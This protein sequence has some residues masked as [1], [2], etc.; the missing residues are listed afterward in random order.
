[1]NS[2]RSGAGRKSTSLSSSSEIRKRPPSK[3]PA[4]IREFLMEGD[5]RSAPEI[6]AH[7]YDRILYQE[8]YRR[9]LDRHLDNSDKHLVVVRGKRR[10]LMAR[11]VQMVAA[12]FLQR[13]RKVTDWSQCEVRLTPA[14]RKSKRKRLPGN[15]SRDLLRQLTPGGEW[16]L[17]AK[18]AHQLTD[19]P[20]MTPEKLEAYYEIQGGPRRTL[21]QRCI[22]AWIRDQARAARGFE[23][24]K[25][26]GS[27]KPRRT[28]WI[29]RTLG[30]APPV[31]KLPAIRKRKEKKKK[32]KKSK[33][34]H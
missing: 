17:I 2:A 10:I 26:Q 18:V 16:Y 34:R 20:F 30:P 29:R 12:G 5:Y 1:M 6:L 28:D 23:G 33:G 14:W 4:L 8:A 9:G 3:L 19:A 21:R 32:K 27:D 7:V 11:I 15:E 24:A 31:P 13:R 22:C 25:S